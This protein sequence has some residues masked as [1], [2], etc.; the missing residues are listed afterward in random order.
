M[1]RQEKDMAREHHFGQILIE[2]PNTIFQLYVADEDELT[3]IQIFMNNL[4]TVHKVGLK[5]IYTWCNRHG[6]AYDVHF[7]YHKDISLWENVTSYCNY[8]HQKRKFRLNYGTV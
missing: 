3:K 6:I 5:D 1:K 2:C 8:F 4:R 7:N